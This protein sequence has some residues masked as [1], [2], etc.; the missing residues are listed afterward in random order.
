MITKAIYPPSK[1]NK[2]DE[3][4]YFDDMFASPSKITPFK[5]LLRRRSKALQ[6]K[7]LRY[8]S[9]VPIT[10]APEP[11]WETPDT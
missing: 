5:L 6:A 2:S 4:Q 1:A 3:Q 11:E 7:S 10:L 9:D 8:R